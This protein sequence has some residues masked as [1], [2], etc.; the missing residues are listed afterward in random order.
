MKIKT[1][2]QI[3]LEYKHLTDDFGVKWVTVDDIRSI[4][5][6]FRTNNYD[7]LSPIAHSDVI[8]LE[9]QLEDTEKVKRGRLYG[10]R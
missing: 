3:I 5:K 7:G 2:Q 10:Y 6:Q 8:R 1:T 9:K 4:L